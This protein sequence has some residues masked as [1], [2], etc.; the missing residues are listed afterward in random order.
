MKKTFSLEHK[1]CT[2]YKDLT[3][4]ETKTVL[5]NV[6]KWSGDSDFYAKTEANLN[7]ENC[8]TT[9]ITNNQ[10]LVLLSPQTSKGE[11][12][13]TLAHETRHVVDS[14]VAENPEIC[15]AQL[16]GDLFMHFADWL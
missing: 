15:P 12:L 13:N 5:E 9:I 3:P 4:E 16:T 6:R 11:L 10:I 8:G 7:N 14:L 2:Y 1:T